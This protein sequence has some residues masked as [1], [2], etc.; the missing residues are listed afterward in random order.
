MASIFD[1]IG[2]I[3]LDGKPV[4]FFDAMQGRGLPQYSSNPFNVPTPTGIN[5]NNLTKQLAE[6]P[7]ADNLAGSQ[8]FNLMNTFRNMFGMP[9][10]N[11]RMVDGQQIT[12]V[13]RNMISNPNMTDQDIENQLAESGMNPMMLQTLMQGLLSQPQQPPMQVM[14]MQQAVRGNPIQ[15]ADLSRFYGGIL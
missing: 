14:P 12:E 8:N 4:T 10:Q 1:E 6:K 11:Q 2:K 15:V 3:G 13:D 5:Y 7:V 9:T